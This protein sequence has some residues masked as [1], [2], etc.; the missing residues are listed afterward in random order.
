[1]N[2]T[3]KKTLKVLDLSFLDLGMECIMKF[4]DKATPLRLYLKTRLY[5][6]KQIGKF[7]YIKEVL[8]FMGKYI[9]SG[10]WKN[11]K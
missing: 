10:E 4:D 7:R 11:A 5:R 2:R 3:V 6:H 8:D 9:E 1:M